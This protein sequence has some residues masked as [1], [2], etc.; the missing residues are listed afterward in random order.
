MLP[1]DNRVY[2]N[3]ARF[4]ATQFREPTLHYE[5]KDLG[6]GYRLGNL[7]EAIGRV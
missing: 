7:L 4:L 5:H 6:L 2:V 3:K 1:T